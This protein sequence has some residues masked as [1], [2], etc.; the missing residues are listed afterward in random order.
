MIGRSFIVVYFVLVVFFINDTLHTHHH[1]WF[2]QIRS[3]GFFFLSLA[4]ITHCYILYSRLI[5]S[6]R[7][8]SSS[9]SSSWAIYILYNH[10]NRKKNYKSHHLKLNLPKGTAY[11]TVQFFFVTNIHSSLLFCKMQLKLTNDQ[12]RSIFIDIKI[13]NNVFFW[14]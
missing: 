6:H 8:S 7:R 4:I 1:H 12:I 5:W 11:V 14:N 13:S 9:S 3:C 10:L 2:D